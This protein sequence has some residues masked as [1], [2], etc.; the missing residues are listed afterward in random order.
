MHEKVLKKVKPYLIPELKGSAARVFEKKIREPST[1]AQKRI[2]M[3][4]KLVFSQVKRRT[5]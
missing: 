2:M 3:E 1:E 5:K 4:A